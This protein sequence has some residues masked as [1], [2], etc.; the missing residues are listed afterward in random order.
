MDCDSLKVAKRGKN[1][2]TASKTL[3]PSKARKFSLLCN[4]LLHG[5]A[6]FGILWKYMGKSFTEIVFIN[7]AFFSLIFGNFE[8]VF[9]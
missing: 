4:I 9:F 6:L 1:D 3:V 7:Q 8:W 2:W 5:L